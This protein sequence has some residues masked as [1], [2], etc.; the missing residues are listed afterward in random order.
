MTTLIGA[1]DHI[2]EDLKG[3][4]DDAARAANT[5][6]KPPVGWSQNSVMTSA[7]ALVSIAA[8]LDRLV[9]SGAGPIAGESIAIDS[10][11]R[12][13]E[14]TNNARGDLATSALEFLHS[15]R[16][17]ADPIEYQSARVARFVSDLL[18]EGYD[19][20]GLGEG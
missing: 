4:R 2:L 6:P 20:G 10:L 18:G 5:M 14:L 16:A 13:V 11:A 9:N 1:L 15:D 17:G 12:V 8:E 19:S 3:L 7:R